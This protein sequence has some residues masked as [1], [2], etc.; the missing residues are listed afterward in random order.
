MNERWVAS[1]RRPL[2]V[3]TFSRSQACRRHHRMGSGLGGLRPPAAKPKR[4]DY[5]GS[6]NH[7]TGGATRP[8]RQ[9]RHF[10]LCGVEP[11]ER[12]RWFSLLHQPSIACSEFP[13]ILRRRWREFCKTDRLAVMARPPVTIE[14]ATASDSNR[15]AQVAGDLIN[16]TKVDIMMV[17][18]TPDTVTP[19]SS[20]VRPTAARWCRPTAHGRPTWQ[21]TEYKW[22]YHSS[23][24]P[25]I[26]L[27]STGPVT[28]RSHPTR[29][30]AMYDNT[31]DG[32]FF[33]AN[34]P[35]FMEAKGY[36][37]VI[38]PTTRRS[39][40][41][42]PPDLGVQELGRRAHHGQYAPADFT[43]FWKQPCSRPGA[44]GLPRRQGHPVPRL[45]GGAG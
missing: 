22:S 9:Q 15:A 33:S 38:L 37:V 24:E 43:N 26:S 29:P 14:L 6:G 12:S 21:N 8:P 2:A 4:H 39:A 13:T 41:I 5:H 35:A 11:G 42:S 27:R 25:R 36:K 30:S 34:A 40:R 16:N 28:R 1:P 20:S 18:S 19:V 45:G 23:S 44:Q 3:A 10:S 7:E 17:A 31:A 32:N